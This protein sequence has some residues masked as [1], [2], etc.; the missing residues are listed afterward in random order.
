M[1]ARNRL[2]RRRS[3][4]SRDPIS[5]FILLAV[6]V[7]VLSL[8]SAAVAQTPPQREKPE[9]VRWLPLT[10]FYDTPHPL[11]P[12]KPGQLIHAEEFDDYALAPGVNAMRILYHSRSSNGEDVASSGVILYPDG[13]P[14]ARGWPIV[15]WAHGVGEVARQC[16]PSLSRILPHGPF[17][18]MYVNL[19]YAVVVTDYAGLGTDFPYAFSDM[20][21][22]AMDVINSIPAARAALPQLAQPWIAVGAESSSRTVIGVAEQEHELHDPN[23]LGSIAIGGLD[24]AEGEYR[25]ADGASPLLLAYGIKAVSPQFEPS[26]VFTEKGIWQYQQ[27]GRS[28]DAPTTAQTGL[29]KPGWQN[30]KFVEDFFRRNRLAQRPLSAPLLLL[31]SDSDAERSAEAGSIVRRLCQH[32]ARVQLQRYDDPQLGNVI[33]DSVRDQMAWIQGRLAGR[34]APSNCSDLR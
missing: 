18:T 32:G 2:S 7:S 4:S 13:K 26:E 27:V 5:F 28:C 25:H 14:P 19:G 21:S 29:V 16:A 33:G 24:D 23:F 30:N 6:Y 3:E 17:L 1:L 31:D 20:Q 34:A 8:M 9:V 10:D 12:G 15:A 11:P 22:N